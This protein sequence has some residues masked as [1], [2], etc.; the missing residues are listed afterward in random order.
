MKTSEHMDK[1]SMTEDAAKAFLSGY[2]IPVI[3]EKTVHTPED[4]AKAAN[5]MG[6]PVVLKG[7]GPTL[8]HKTERGL[9]HLDIHDEAGAM[10]AA[11]AIIREAEEE[12]SGIL[13][14]P[15]I[16]GKREFVAGLF[17]D[18][19]FGPIVMFGLGG[20]FTEALTDV[21]FRVVPITEKD[22]KAMIREIRAKSL[23]NAFR[24]EKAVDESALAAT[25]MALSKIGMEKADIAE[26]D[27][28]PLLVTPEGE[29][30]AVDA[31]V[32]TGCKT[33]QR[34]FLPPVD[35]AALGKCFHPRSIAFV[36]AT[37]TLGKWGHTLM[38]NTISKGYKGE[39]YLVNP[40]G[41][42]IAGRPVYKSV[43][44]IPGNVDLGVVTIPA[45]RVMDLIPLFQEKGIRNM[46]LITSG[47]AETGEEGR[48]LEKELVHAAEKAGIIV[49]G[50]NTMGISNPHINL[51]CVGIHL[52]NRP[53]STA[54]VAQ[55]GNMGTQ[56]LGFAEQQD[57]GIRGF[58]GSGNE[59]MVTI[60]D[61]LE[62][63][64]EDDSTRLVMLYIESVKNGRRFFKIA[65][66][67]S[68]KKPIILLKG[69][70][71]EAGTRAAASHTGAMASDARVFDAACTQAGIVKVELPMDML[72]LS[73][74]FTSLP[75]PKGNR[76]A[77]M[78]LGGGWGVVTS[79]LCAENGLV[80]PELTPDIT[81]RIDDILPPYWSRA[82]PIDIVG[83]AG[84]NIPDIVLEELLK[85]DGCDAVINL[86]IIGRRHLLS[87]MIQ[88][89]RD[90][91]PGYSEEFLRTVQKRLDDYEKSYIETVVQLM[92]KY[93]KPVYGVI[94]LKSEDDRTLY[95]VP[96]SRY[97]GLFFP[98]PERAVR[99]FARMME[100]RR[101]LDFTEEQDA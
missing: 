45:S 41:G 73:A 90:A 29:V 99:A 54:M 17:R 82:N 37:S 98:T 62:A 25:L 11:E 78:T 42:T 14:Q 2:G 44:D 5:Q 68:R 35:P 26:I 31:L 36:G 95:R 101:F 81:N 15:K 66:R 70:R 87:R 60:E 27:I 22:A 52:K 39:I 92:E 46:L 55:S 47:F 63:F 80:L 9:V 57:L 30:V 38:T 58:S 64:E 1:C 93:Q 89:V 84:N 49:M 20:I 24:G 3:S 33:E 79:D 16:S 18:P 21:S 96:G 74:A 59:A 51:Y 97:K 88:S 67:I 65:K 69:G 7:I 83:E 91:D 10:E 77:I 4:A 86:G 76:A 53:G 12:L 6:Y 19:L 32:A 28:N 13:V 72:D 71:S 85:W 94:I 61:Y 75:L 50:P 40:K 23:L 34:E 56:L 43:A 100:Y 8:L 48:K